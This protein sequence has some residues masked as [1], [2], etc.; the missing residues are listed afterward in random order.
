MND[1]ARRL[2]RVAQLLRWTVGTMV[3]SFG[4]AWF[5]AAHGMLV[6]LRIAV[7]AGAVAFVIATLCFVWLAWQAVTRRRAPKPPDARCDDP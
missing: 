3:L 1:F 6:L 2:R 7:L 5:A 4:L